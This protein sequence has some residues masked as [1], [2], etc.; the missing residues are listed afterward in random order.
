MTPWTPTLTRSRAQQRTEA[1]QPAASGPADAHHHEADAEETG[2]THTEHGTDNQV[3][4]LTLRDL[5]VRY[6]PAASPAVE[7]VSLTVPVGQT[8]AVVGESGSGKS[9]TAAV[10]A[11]LLPG[12]AHARTAEQRLMGQDMRG[13]S[14][15][16]WKNVRGDLL[17]YV[18]QDTGTGLNP[19]RTIASQLSETLRA[20]G[21]ARR[22]AAARIATALADVGLDPELHGSRYPHELS[23]GQRQRVLIAL[24]LAR[25][26]RLVIADEPTSALDVSAQK[27]IL[28]LLEDR[29][30][31]AGAGLLLITHDLGVARDRADSILVME[32]GRVVEEGRAERVFAD[33]QHE[34]TRRLLSASPAVHA[35]P[36][37]KTGTVP[38]GTT[39]VV[40]AKGL[41][42]AFGSG[43]HRVQA[44]T[45]VDFEL[46]PGRTLGIV[47]ESG[48]GKSTTARILLGLES[49][50]QGELEVFGKP[51]G[52][53]RRQ[54]RELATR[55]RFVHQDPTG[56]LDPKYTVAASIGEPLRGFRIGTRAERAERVNELL[57]LV[58]LPRDLAGRRPAELS[59]GQRQRVSIARALAVGPELIVLD[60]PVSALDVSVQAQIL[61]LLADLQERLGLS[62]VF[63]SHDL[64]VIRQISDDVLVMAEGRVIESGPAGE[65]FD[66]PREQLTRTLIEAVPGTR[67]E[68]GRANVI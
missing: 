65:V 26:P 7:G 25:E 51:L 61:D 37:R 54:G 14:D 24:A 57:D 5:T 3:A 31:R 55:A 20:A 59:G 68:S 32:K 41:S 46:A 1:S 66:T 40:R 2:R 53:N 28:D 22:Q 60:E 4:A 30:A 45:D 21:T 39:P 47:G 50:D 15:T 42:R 9:T 63:I 29:V 35:V 34:Y 23:G 8:L 17:G 36:H 56:S 13:A 18:P 16:V 62:Y 43:P 67:H 58:A 10:A 27:S 44:V 12:S 49:Y 52:H 11:G 64:A 48:S 6:A 19:V 33:P 38:E